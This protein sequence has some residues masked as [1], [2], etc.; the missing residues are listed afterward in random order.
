MSKEG[1]F[2]SVLY[3]YCAWETGLITNLCAFA[4]D[5]T[6]MGTLTRL[7]FFIQPWDGQTIVTG[8]MLSVVPQ[9]TPK[10]WGEI[11][12]ILSAPET[13]KEEVS[14][15][16]ADAIEKLI[17]TELKWT[18]QVGDAQKNVEKIISSNSECGKLQDL[19]R[20]LATEKAKLPDPKGLTKKEQLAL[21]QR[22]ATLNKQL[23]ETQ[24]TLD[25]CIANLSAEIKENVKRAQRDEKSPR[26]LAE[27]LVGAAKE[28]TDPDKTKN[29]WPINL[30]YT[31]IT[32]YVVAKFSFADTETYVAALPAQY[33]ES[34][35]KEI[36]PFEKLTKSLTQTDA[37]AL[38]KSN[39]ALLALNSIPDKKLAEVSYRQDVPFAKT[40]FSD[41][42]ETAL[43]N[44]VNA[45]AFDPET[46]TISLSTLKAKQEVSLNP[47]LDTFY[48]NFP[49]ADSQKDTAAHS[50][51]AGIL[52]DNPELEYVRADKK[53]EVEPNAENMLK[54]IGLL[55]F[56]NPE[57]LYSAEEVLKK[58]SS[59]AQ[60]TLKKKEGAQK[61][62]HYLVVESELPFTLSCSTAHAEFALQQTAELSALISYLIIAYKKTP[63]PVGEQLVT[64]FLASGV[65]IFFI[66]WAAIVGDH[67]VPRF[68]LITLIIFKTGRT[69]FGA[70]KKIPSSYPYF[71]NALWRLAFNDPTVRDDGALSERVQSIIN[72]IDL[73]KR[74][75]RDALLKVHNNRSIFAEFVRLHGPNTIFEFL[76]PD[77][78]D[79]LIIKEMGKDAELVIAQAVA[80]KC[81]EGLF[82]ADTRKIGDAKKSIWFGET[83]PPLCITLSPDLI[84]KIKKQIFTAELIENAK[85]APDG[86]LYRA[87]HALSSK[88][89][90]A[91][92][93]FELE[94][95]T[96]T[97]NTILKSETPQSRELRKAIRFAGDDREID[98]AIKQA[99]TQK[100]PYAQFD[101]FISSIL[102]GIY[103]RYPAFITTIVQKKA[104]PQLLESLY[105]GPLTTLLAEAYK[106]I[107][108]GIKIEDQPAVITEAEEQLD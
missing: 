23:K 13:G 84:E 12:G 25:A 79:C 71:P 63:T 10:M 75:L 102:L 3:G 34:T 28:C 97:A 31:V 108:E 106:A 1:D 94:S 55:I 98:A 15:P 11:V 5:N 70:I 14:V 17:T 27:A 105:F 36:P 56:Y 61:E 83:L 65:E 37:L 29:I 54:A 88:L 19:L 7:L 89:L 107:G 62:K 26:K 21:Q 68:A 92:N 59:L 95:L 64:A 104:A 69:A 72:A 76:S 9:I 73:W 44:A 48:K 103:S 4:P 30:V 39:P 85:P 51:W 100:W 22:N 41:C 96:T 86:S 2:A 66:E 90:D 53:Y 20:N 49:T 18:Q 46:G 43:L 81:D 57:R 40:T 82:F 32:A 50:M 80:K 6:A 42:A 45:L 33:R 78:S 52:A 60:T 87:K 91:L 8:N 74:P 67:T 16:K 38:F 77:D 99:F 58:L 35:K 24:K 47:E 101:Q 93:A